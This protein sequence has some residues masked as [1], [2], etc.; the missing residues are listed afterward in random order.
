MAAYE[1][2]W[3]VSYEYLEKHAAFVNSI[4]SLML[5]RAKHLRVSLFSNALEK[6]ALFQEDFKVAHD[7][8]QNM[9]KTLQ[10]VVNDWKDLFAADSFAFCKQSVAVPKKI[11]E[12][13]NAL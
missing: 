3:D 2:L 4:T 1:Q 6:R 11:E 13:D 7:E 10:T 12:P 8:L 9:T 5:E